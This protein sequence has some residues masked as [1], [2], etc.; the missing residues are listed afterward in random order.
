MAISFTQ[1]PASNR[2]P[3]PYVEVDGSNALGLQAPEPH[4]VLMIG[5]RLS[6]GTALQA[7]IKRIVG[8]EDGDPLFGSKSM[9]A[10]GTRAF[11]RVNRTADLYAMAMDE[12]AGGTAASGTLVFAG[13]STADGTLTARI[14]DTRISISVASGTA[15]AAAASALNTAIGAKDRCPCS[16]GVVSA[17][18]TVTSRHKGT[19]GNEIT[20]EVEAIPAGLTVTPTAGT[21]AALT[22]G[23]TNPDIATAIAAIDEDWYDTIVVLGMTDATNMLLIEAEGSRRWGP[24]VK[25]PG[26]VVAATRGTHG[27]LTTYGNSRNS[28]F[29]SVMGTG[30]SPTPPYIWAAQAAARDAQ[31]CDTQPNRPRNGLT[32]PDCEAPKKADRFDAQQRNLLLVDGISTYKVDASGRVMIERLITTYQTNTASLADAT[33]LAMETQRN[34]ARLYREALTIGGKYSDFLLAPNGTKASPGVPI[35]TPDSYRGEM[36]A[37]NDSWERRGYTKDADGFAEDIVCEINELD[38]ERLDVQI[39]P[40]LVGGLVTLAHKISFR[41]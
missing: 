17:T 41:L 24:L 14:G 37:L 31:R 32:L 16:S 30:L 6:T 38:V 19:A 40:R 21:G 22:S 36:I 29:S 18:V 13:T 23:A 20:I 3:G 5:I 12:N 8:T 15:A 25:Q 39:A 9:L 11:K 34:L 10:L 28:A 1:M 35:V 26:M 7:E 2:V 27:T 4:K 33:Y